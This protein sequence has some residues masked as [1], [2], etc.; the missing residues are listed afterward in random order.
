MD[1]RLGAELGNE[2]GASGA[3]GWSEGLRLCRAEKQTNTGTSSAVSDQ[4]M[5]R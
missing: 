1:W 2:T 5:N 3:L 4:P